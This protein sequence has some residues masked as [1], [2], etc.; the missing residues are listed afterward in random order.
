MYVGVTH[1]IRVSIGSSACLEIFSVIQTAMCEKSSI[2]IEA[3]HEMVRCH[4]GHYEDDH[5]TEKQSGPIH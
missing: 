3:T 1:Y 2:M 4:S 5:Y